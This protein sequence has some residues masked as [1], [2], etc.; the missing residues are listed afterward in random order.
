MPPSQVF[1][2]GFL[3][4]VPLIALGLYLGNGLEGL[5]DSEIRRLHDAIDA[6]RKKHIVENVQAMRTWWKDRKSGRE[7]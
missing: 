5:W 7:E 6:R 3:T 1:G 2:L 4:G